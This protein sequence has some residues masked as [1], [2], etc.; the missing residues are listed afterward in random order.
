MEMVLSTI[1]LFAVFALLLFLGCPI[2]VS[3]LISSVATALTQLT[4]DQVAFIT[5]QKMNSGVESFS[6]LAVPL[7]ILAGNIM[8]NGGIARRLINFAKLLS[9][10]IPGSLAQTNV[11]GNMLFGALS[12]SAVAAA[13]AIGGTLNPMEE[14]EGY[15]PAFSTCVN[16]ASA[17]TGLLIPPTSAFIV[18]STIAGGVSISALFM[19]G[20]V[21]GILMGLATMIIAFVYAKK[22]NYPVSPK[23]SKKE[24][25]RISIEA[26]PSLLLIIIVIGGIVGGIF[27]ATEGAGIAVLDRKSV[28]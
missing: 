11:L 20:Y 13:A 15:D 1:I 26:I 22:H 18:Y 25:L 14:E 24:A 6:L 9:G 27:T 28:V 3:I 10:R 23:V 4:W 2:S 5:M 16:I 8:N 7:F 17:P 19:A 12:G 21:P